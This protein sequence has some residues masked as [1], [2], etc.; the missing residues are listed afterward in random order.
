[1]HIPMIWRSKFADLVNNKKNPQS[2]ENNGCRLK[3]LDKSM[4]W[5]QKN[6]ETIKTFQKLQNH[7]LR[8]ITFKKC[9]DHM[10]AVHTKNAKY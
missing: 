6:N 8:K 3:C 2:L 10:S 1:M 7:A 9:H 4:L 5:G